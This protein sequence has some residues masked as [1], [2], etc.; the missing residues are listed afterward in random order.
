MRKD[1]I[2]EKARAEKSDE[3]EQHFNDKS[4]FFIIIAM[5]LCLCLFSITR[6]VKDVPV[7]DY[8]ATLDISIAAGHFYRYS[9]TKKAESLAIGICFGIAGIIFTAIYFA[10]FFGA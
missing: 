10:K 7:E 4:M 8:V 9:K 6:M 1:E 2:L 3:M 5:F